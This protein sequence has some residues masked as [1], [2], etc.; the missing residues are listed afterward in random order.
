MRSSIDFSF[1]PKQKA[2]LAD[3]GVSDE[4]KLEKVV[5]LRVHCGHYLLSSE[6]VL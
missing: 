5:I 3:S 6:K 1:L 4:K 2:R